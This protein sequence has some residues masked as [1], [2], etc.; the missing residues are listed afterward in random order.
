M[1]IGI[2]GPDVFVRDPSEARFIAEV[3]GE[4]AANGRYTYKRAYAALRSLAPQE[5]FDLYNVWR[6]DGNQAFRDVFGPYY[7]RAAGESINGP[8]FEEKG[9]S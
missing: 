8:L 1:A 6:N 4:C 9:V 2:S 5:L 3:L 7:H